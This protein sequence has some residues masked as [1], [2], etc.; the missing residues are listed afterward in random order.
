MKKFLVFSGVFLLG[1]VVAVIIVFLLINHY[2]G[3]STPASPSVSS[4][5]DKAKES[6]AKV[7][8]TVPDSGLPLKTLK[9][10]DQQKTAAKTVGINPDTFVITK[11]MLACAIEK[12]G[13]ARVTEIMSGATPSVLETAKLLPCAK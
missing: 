3:T 9:L 11:T 12:I 8:Q 13:N 4:T 5:T 1:A 10:S 2:S 7:L 6:A